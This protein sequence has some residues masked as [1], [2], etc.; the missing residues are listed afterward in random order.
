M[1]SR[2]NSPCWRSSQPKLGI[3]KPP[4]KTANPE[5]LVSTACPPLSPALLGVCVLA[6]GHDTNRR[7]PRPGLDKHKLA[8]PGSEK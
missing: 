7:V 5:D 6:R 1:E 3:G 8:G 4:R 2:Y